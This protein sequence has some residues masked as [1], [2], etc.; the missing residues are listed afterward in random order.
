MD[1]QRDLDKFIDE[2]RDRQ[3]KASRI[4]PWLFVAV[5]EIKL[6][7]SNS[8]AS[9]RSCSEFF[10]RDRIALL[11]DALVGHLWRKFGGHLCLC[12]R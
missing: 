2:S 10:T 6:K 11:T 7:F 4:W 12:R 5:I 1:G 9:G 8:V 3:R